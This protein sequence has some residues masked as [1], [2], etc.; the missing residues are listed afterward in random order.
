MYEKKKVDEPK[1]YIERSIAFTIVT[2]I[3]AALLD[4]LSIYMLININPWGTLVGVP[5][6]ALTLQA[7][8]LMVNPYAIIFDDKF[9][10]KQSLLYNRE[11]YFLD[12]KNIKDKKLTSFTMVYNDDDLQSLPFLGVRQSQRKVFLT[13]LEQHIAESMK[14]RDF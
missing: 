5:A 6:I 13:H 1:H 2:C 7:L 11:F 9:E 14:G 3:I 4:W 8:W 12:V 10:I